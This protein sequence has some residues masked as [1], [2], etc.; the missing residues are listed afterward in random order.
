MEAAEQRFKGSPGIYFTNY[1]GMSVVQ[2]TE[3]RKK[4]REKNVEFTVVKNTLNK[5]YNLF[6]TELKILLKILKC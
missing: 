3:L 2:A 6:Y 1:S 5:I 4:F